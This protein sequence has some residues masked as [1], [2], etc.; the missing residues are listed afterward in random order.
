MGI[1]AGVLETRV[2]FAGIALM[3]ETASNPTALANAFRRVFKGEEFY[4]MPYP[5]ALTRLLR[6]A[7]GGQA[8]GDQYRDRVLAFL[9]S[10]QPLFAAFEAAWHI[11][12]EDIVAK[13]CFNQSLAQGLFALQGKGSAEQ[14][15]A[16]LFLQ[17]IE[18]MTTAEVQL[19]V[20]CH[21]LL[22]GARAQA[23]VMQFLH[24]AGYKV[25]VP[26]FENRAEVEQ[27]DVRG[28]SD[29]VAIHPSGNA[30][31]LIDAKGSELGGHRR[32]VAAARDEQY[33]TK[34]SVQELHH[35]IAHEVILKVGNPEYNEQALRIFHVTITI[36]SFDW[37]M[38]TLG[39]VS[40]DISSNI[41]KSFD[42]IISY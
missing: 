25:F 18:A 3:G 37:G 42:R 5:K 8:T 4:C 16:I 21:E 35:H 41:L 40:P 30:L 1:D 20:A 36:P 7:K 28:G 19:G 27:W 29:V 13:A 24:D 10:F 31:F 2:G 26:D 32:N 17:T 14:Q 11:S 6:E 39:M 33:V 23:G 9:R 38:G 34:A 22:K 15:P 12:K